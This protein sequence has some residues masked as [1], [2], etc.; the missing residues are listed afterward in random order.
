M[1]RSSCFH[2]VPAESCREVWVDFLGRGAPTAGLL[3]AISAPS[4]V[5]A[6]QVHSTGLQDCPS[7]AAP[8]APRLN[9]LILTRCNPP[10]VPQR[11][12]AQPWSILEHPRSGITTGSALRQH[13]PHSCKVPKSHLGWGNWCVH[14]LLPHPLLCSAESQSPD[15][16]LL[17]PPSGTQG[18][19]TK[20][21]LLQHRFTQPKPL[22]TLQ[23]C[24]CS[25]TNT[26][27]IAFPRHSCQQGCTGFPLGIEE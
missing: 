2:P 21:R 27:H 24:H 7:S 14:C 13:K 8:V 25:C 17:P 18:F 23:F 19:T 16:L 26:N 9:S 22:F 20:Q 3:G 12:K 1:G 11:H 15:M 4:P 6:N 5:P 10:S